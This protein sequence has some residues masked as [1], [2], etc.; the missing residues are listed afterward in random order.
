MGR[1]RT[2]DADVTLGCYGD[3]SSCD[4]TIPTSL[5]NLFTH[6]FCLLFLIK[7]M[8]DRGC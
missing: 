6:N 2:L 7:H 5:F 3:Y 4:S 1:C 8:L